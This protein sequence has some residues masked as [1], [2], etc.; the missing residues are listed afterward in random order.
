[1][2]ENPSSANTNKLFDELWQPL[3]AFEENKL[4]SEE[5][6]HWFSLLVESGYIWKLPT[7]Y[8]LHAAKLL[9]NGY[10][11]DKHRELDS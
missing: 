10:V 1:M 7:T 4:G 2:S 6:Q 11:G 8:V 9:D 3:F 5:I